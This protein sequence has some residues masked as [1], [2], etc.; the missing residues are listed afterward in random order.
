M[1]FLLMFL[2][3]YL[4]CR[5]LAQSLILGRMPPGSPS[6][7]SAGWSNAW[8]LSAKHGDNLAHRPLGVKEP[9]PREKQAGLQGSKQARHPPSRG[10]LGDDWEHQTCGFLNRKWF[11]CWKL[12]LDELIRGFQRMFQVWFQAQGSVLSAPLS[13]RAWQFLTAIVTV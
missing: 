7:Q 8:R 13:T 12:I 5:F 10:N 2:L 9:G 6:I 1:G 4:C 11:W 3:K